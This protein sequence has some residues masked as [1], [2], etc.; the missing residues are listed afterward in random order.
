LHIT[1]FSALLWAHVIKRA[2]DVKNV[3]APVWQRATA[4]FASKAIY[5]ISIISSQMLKN[6]S[7]DKK[8]LF[9]AGY[10]R[11]RGQ[12]CIILAKFHD[13]RFP[14]SRDAMYDRANLMVAAQSADAEIPQKE[15]MKRC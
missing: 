14:R 8:F 9:Q 6:E 4:S 1:P 10:S 7:F 2:F 11:P 3:F 15:D 12:F 5:I 13:I